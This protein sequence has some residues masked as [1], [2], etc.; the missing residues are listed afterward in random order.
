MSVTGVTL[1]KNSLEITVGDPDVKLTAT[2]APENATDKTVSW[3]SDKTEFATVD[4]QGNVH[5]V[6][7]GIANI[8]VTTADGNKTATCAVAVKAAKVPVTGVTLDKTT[9]EITVGD[10]DVKLAATV[11]PENATDKTVSWSSDKTEFATVDNQGNVH[12]VAPGIA[13]I[14]VTTTDGNKTATCAV[15]VKAALPEGFVDL[16]VKDADG[17]SLYWSEKNLGASNPED[18]GDYFAW[19]ETAPYYTTTGGWP[20][21]PTW[22][23]GK[24]GYKWGSYC[25]QSSI[26]EWS[27]PPYDATTKILLPAYDAA[28]K[29]NSSWRTPTS[30]EFKALAAGCVW[31]WTTDYNSTGKAGY[32]VYKAKNDADKGKADMNGTWKKWD[33]SQSK[34]VTDGASEATGYTTSDTHIFFPAAGNGNGLGLDFAGSAGCYWSSSLYTDDTERA[35]SLFF[36]SGSVEPQDYRYRFFGISVRPVKDAAAPLPAGEFLTN[37]EIIKSI[38]DAYK[39]SGKTGYVE[40]T[41]KSASGDWQANT[42]VAD[43]L[44]F[45]Q[46]KNNNYS[47]LLSPEFSGNITKIELVIN[48]TTMKRNFYAL[49]VSTELTEATYTNTIFDTAYG[50]ATCET[51][52]E[53]TITIVFNKNTKHFKLIVADGTAYIDAIK[54]YHN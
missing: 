8:T 16:G 20:A 32:I 34:Y 27:T 47:H 9:L 41:I 6:A 51:K 54:V 36:K 45:L 48:K 4:N 1:D 53:Q 29:T 24:T 11:L 25:G 43:A 46:L 5:A 40:Y 7:P 3:S 22:K 31:I 42:N 44:K 2:I 49:P 12:A 30:D 15:T 50:S 33:V 37:A 19:G 52:K 10:P 35:Y 13:N 18:Y 17:K 26:V 14:T 38:S 28:T 23:E 21:T 39:T